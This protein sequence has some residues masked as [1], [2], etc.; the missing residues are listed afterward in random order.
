MTL[1][2]SP[3]QEAAEAKRQ[4]ILEAIPK[5]WRME[6]IPPVEKQVDV[7][8]GYIHQYLSPQEIEITEADAVAIASHTTLGEWSAVEVTE[9]FCHRA[10]IAHQLVCPFILR[11]EGMSKYLASDMDVGTDL[12][13]LG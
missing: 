13:L 3:W 9:A 10:A 1:E 2:K 6:R 8:G 12:A 4:A 11:Q 5:K 7:T